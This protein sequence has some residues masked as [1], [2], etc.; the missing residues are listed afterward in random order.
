MT[1]LKEE[2]KSQGTRTVSPPGVNH[3]RSHDEESTRR[4]AQRT[5]PDTPQEP[6]EEENITEEVMINIVTE[7]L[8]SDNEEMLE[9]VLLTLKTYLYGK[10]GMSGAERK[11]AREAFCQVGGPLAVVRVMKEHPNGTM[12]QIHGINIL[13]GAAF[14]NPYCQT[15]VAK[16]GS[17][18]AILVAM[19]RFSCDKSVISNGFGALRDIVL[20]NELNAAL[21]ATKISGIPALV[22]RMTECKA[23]EDIIRRAC[24]LL[25]H[26][27]DF[28]QLRQSLVDAKVLIT[29]AHG[30]DDHKDND[31]IQ[32]AARQTMKLLV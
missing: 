16:V 1:T 20:E 24:Q 29:L 10:D 8:R 13:W 23:D 9:R 4:V 14:N 21:L 25:K 11:K 26:L 17:V 28:E 6:D 18:Q 12:L 2:I 7:D 3:E 27:A 5:E 30:I 15:A 22:K 19:D 32:E 31:D